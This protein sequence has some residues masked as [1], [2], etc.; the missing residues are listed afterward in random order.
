MRNIFVLEDDGNRMK[1]F[2]GMFLEDNLVMTNT[3]KSALSIFNSDI[4]FD[5]IYLDH[6]LGGNVFVSSEDINTGAYVSKHMYGLVDKDTLI[7]IHSYNPTGAS[8]IKQNLISKGFKNVHVI[9]FSPKI[10]EVS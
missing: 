3:A 8:N 9:P 7:I 4:E 6:D 1:A 10:F 2:A 5:V